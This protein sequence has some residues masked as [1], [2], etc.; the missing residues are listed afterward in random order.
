MEPWTP[1]W[2]ALRFGFH[3]LSFRFILIFLDELWGGC[4]S[5][6]NGLGLLDRGLLNWGLLDLLS[7]LRELILRNLCDC[8]L[9]LLH[10]LGW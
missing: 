5:W 9:S 4:G 8:W 10:Q 3:L 6:L 7:W 2:G 1:S